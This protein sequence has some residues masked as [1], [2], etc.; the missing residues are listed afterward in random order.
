MKDD[1]WAD[2][3]TTT[4]E[5]NAAIERLLIAAEQNDINPRGSWVCDS[6]DEL[7][8]S[9]ETVIIELG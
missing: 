6:E 9:Y 3:V 4:A 2:V 5:F 1:Q 8:G 7:Q